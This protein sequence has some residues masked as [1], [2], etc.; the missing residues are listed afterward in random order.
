LG[1]DGDHIEGKGMTDR[2]EQVARAAEA[3][4]VYQQHCRTDHEHAI[5]DLICDLGHLAEDRGFDFVSEA[6]RGIRHR[7]AE[8]QLGTVTIS[9]RTPQSRSQ[10][11]GD[12]RHTAND[13]QSY[14]ARRISR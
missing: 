8:R 7:F 4:V 14:K 5:S 11:I 10:S 3:I 6:R 13:D 1:E 12:N 2:A 9:G